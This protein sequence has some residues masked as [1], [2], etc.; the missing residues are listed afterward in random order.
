LVLLKLNPGKVLDVLNAVR[1]LADKP[2]AG[3]DLRY[4]MNIFGTWDVGLWVNS[5][6]ANQTLDFV[7]RKI[8]D[9][10]GVTE[11]YTVPTFP[12]GNIARDLK[13]QEEQKHPL[14][15]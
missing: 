11:V 1:N 3:V 12:H 5:E 9:I 6:D 2:V 13:A 10:S 15:T 7:Q 8:K 14:R 4:T